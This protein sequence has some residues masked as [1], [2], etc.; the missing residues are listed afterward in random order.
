MEKKIALAAVLGPT[1]SGKTALGIALA[2]RY[3]GEIVSCDSMQIYRGL[4]I[5]TAKP[6][7]DELN[8]APHHLIGF[9]DVDRA[10]SVSEYVTMAEQTIHEICAAGKHP[11]LVGGTGLYARSLLRGVSFD[12][13]GRDENLRSSLTEEAALNGI[14]PLYERLSGLDP[15]AARKIHPHNEKR[16]IRA[17]E[18]CLATGERFSEQEER[19]RRA[20]PRYRSLVLCLSFRDRQKL[21]D[22]IN[23]RVE[24]VMNAGL[25]EEA[26][27]FYQVVRESRRPLTAAQ[28]IGYKELFPFFDGI[29]SLEEA[30]EN[31]KRET[32]RYAKR[33][34]TWFN[35]EQDAIFLYVD[36]WKD[37]QELLQEAFRIWEQSG[38]FSEKGE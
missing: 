20:P 8:A 29:L 14:E 30:V 18:F 16:V 23:C 6:S 33:Q 25:E 22:R 19:S 37:E 24:A 13:R 12:E 35:R 21:Y 26:R 2:R 27:A 36:D 10:F 3:G 38:L 31:I 34:L 4:S 1:A 28:A 32:R 11:I 5:G 17:L 7:S 15:Q 9:C